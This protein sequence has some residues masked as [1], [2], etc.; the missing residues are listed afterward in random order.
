MDLER[1][2]KAVDKIGG[3]FKLT[4]LMQKRLVELRR[5]APPLVPAEENDDDYDVVLEEILQGKLNFE[6]RF[7]EE[8]V[9][10]EEE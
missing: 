9:E 7:D 4:V 6:D 5:G 3:R 10:D 1:I 2:E 8:D